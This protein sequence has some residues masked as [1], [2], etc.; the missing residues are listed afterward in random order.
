MNVIYVYYHYMSQAVY[1]KLQEKARDLARELPP[2]SF[3]RDHGFLLQRSED[4]LLNHD[5]VNKCR[6]HLNESQLECAHGLCHC[7][8]VARDAGVIV[9]LESREMDLS[10]AETDS[11]F[12]TAVIAGLLHDIKRKEQDHAVRGSIESEKILTKIG[13]ALRDRQYVADAIRNHEAFQETFDRD[14]IAGKLVSDALYDAD[15]FRWGPENFSV[16]LWLMVTAHKTPIEALYR[17]FREKMKGIEK[18]K[19]TFRT[20]TGKRYGPEF[21]DQGIAIGNAIYEEMSLLQGRQ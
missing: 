3:Y 21:I 17:T 12:V 19:E 13:M 11:L 1:Q 8:A 14:D 4:L 9:L 15:K 10:P 5:L 2:P 7:E 16:T 20:E 18:I 6:T